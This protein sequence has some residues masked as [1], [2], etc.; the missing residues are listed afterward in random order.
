MKFRSFS[1]RPKEPERK[2][3]ETEIMIDGHDTTAVQNT[4]QYK[5]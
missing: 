3:E 5:A 2:I 1:I 4:K